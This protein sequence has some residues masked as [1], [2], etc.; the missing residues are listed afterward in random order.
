MDIDIQ[1]EEAEGETEGLISYC[2]HIDFLVD[3]Q[4]L[5]P[6]MMTFFVPI[7]LWG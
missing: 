6:K 4:Y 1:E 7:R 3:K 2:W 5:T